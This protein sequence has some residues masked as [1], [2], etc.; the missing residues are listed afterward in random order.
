MAD[1]LERSSQ[2]GSGPEAKPPRRALAAAAAAA[3]DRAPDVPLLLAACALCMLSA[4]AERERSADA[5]GEPG[6]RVRLGEARRHAVELLCAVW[7]A[8]ARSAAAI[9]SVS[10][11]TAL[12][13][14]R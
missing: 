5:G 12:L 13:A 9:D 14:A 3:A 8:L 4:L 1:L 6:V 2:Q 11:M 10:R 7:A